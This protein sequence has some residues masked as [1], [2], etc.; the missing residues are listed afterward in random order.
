MVNFKHKYYKLDHDIFPTVRSVNYN[1]KHGIRAGSVENVNVD[2]ICKGRAMLIH[3]EQKQIEQMSLAF[4]QFDANH[5]LGKI[6]V[7]QDYIDLLNSFLP[8]GWG[9]NT[10]TTMKAILWW[11]WT[12]RGIEL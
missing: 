1:G 10:L 3:V 5:P 12:K 6:Y 8:K 9:K 11:R 2:H 4:L 7:R